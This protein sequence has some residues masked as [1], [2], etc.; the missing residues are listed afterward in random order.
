MRS[1]LDSV[2]PY[3][4]PPETR[5]L[6]AI[7]ASSAL[8]VIFSPVEIAGER[9]IDLCTFGAVPS[10]TL[11]QLY[12]VDVLI[13]TNT[14]PSYDRLQRL[15]PPGLKEFVR[16]GQESLRESLRACDVVMTPALKGSLADFHKG[17]SFIEAGRQS[18]TASLPAIERLLRLHG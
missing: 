10:R 2:E 18:V 8:P 13:A 3:V 6:D 16:G 5:I 9:Y 14:T 15:P 17:A 1:V 11:R 4:F 12:D 7:A